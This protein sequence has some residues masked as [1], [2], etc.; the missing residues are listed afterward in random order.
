MPRGR[1]RGVAVR[2]AT[3][4]RRRPTFESRPPLHLI[5]RS[6][7]VAS[8]LCH[9]N[10]VTIAAF[11]VRVKL[12]VVPNRALIGLSFLGCYEQTDL[13]TPIR[14]FYHMGWQKP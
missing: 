13:I 9:W 5:S 8:L 14:L 6:V 10:F 3:F 2:R 7:V 1:H 4:T 11:R 12:W